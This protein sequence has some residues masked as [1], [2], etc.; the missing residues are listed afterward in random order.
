VAAGKAVFMKFDRSAG[1][2]PATC[3]V[4]LGSFTDTGVLAQGHIEFAPEGHAPAG[5]MGDHRHDAGEWMFGYRYLSTDYSGLY[6]GSGKISAMTAAMA[7]YAMVPT[8][9]NMEMHMLD[10]MY[11]PTDNITLMLMPMYMTMD[12]TMMATPMMPG[13]DMGHAGHATGAHSHSISGLGDTNASALIGLAHADDWSLHATVGVSIP[14]GSVDEK[15]AT[16]NYT[17]YGMQLGSGTWD[18]MPGLTYMAKRDALSWG[19]QVGAVLPMEDSND[20]GF[21]VGERYFA[22][23]WTAYRATDWL[24]LSGRMV[25]DR[26]G[27]INGHYDGPHNH[28]SPPDFQ[29]NYGGEFVDFGLGF[30]VVAQHGPLAGIRVGVEWIENVKASFNGIQ[31]G[32]DDGLNISLAYAFE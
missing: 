2:I 24:S 22:T 20:S 12:M 3:F 9:M 25:Y 31:L 7:G 30:N 32:R 5:V 11:A 28:T 6:Q 8:S 17:H 19:A 18:F 1:L 27:D 26:K 14:T 13:M 16:G 4:L 15:G 29:A 23:A 21:S 10:I